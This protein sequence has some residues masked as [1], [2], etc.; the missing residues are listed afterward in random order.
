MKYLTLILLT[1]LISGY[2]KSPVKN[3]HN[4]LTRELSNSILID[5]V[6]IKRIELKDICFIIGESTYPKI[7]GLKDKA[8]QKQLNDTSTPQITN[9]HRVEKQEPRG[10]R[11]S[12]IFTYS[13]EKLKKR[14]R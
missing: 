11:G 14:I 8:F 13:G 10:L 6:K 7:T 2:G 5:S 12:V 4:Q 3:T 1:I 9:C